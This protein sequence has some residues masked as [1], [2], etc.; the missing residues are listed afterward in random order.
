MTMKGNFT[1]L[2]MVKGVAEMR[3]KRKWRNNEVL[4]DANVW[5]DGRMKNKLLNE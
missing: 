2:V 1:G 4:I 5:Q 3:V